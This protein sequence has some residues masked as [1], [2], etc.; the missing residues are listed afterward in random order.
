MEPFEPHDDVPSA[1]V[2][3]FVDWMVGLERP[4][5]GVAV[6]VP[7]LFVEGAGDARV[8]PVGKVH[9]AKVRPQSPV[10]GGGAVLTV[11]GDVAEWPVSVVSMKRWFVVFVRVPVADGVTLTLI[12]QL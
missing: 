8:K 12:T 9:L 2:V 1:V 10:P 5:P 4:G 3:L 6:A 7:T 11:S